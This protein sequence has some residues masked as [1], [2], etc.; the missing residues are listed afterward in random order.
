[1]ISNLKLLVKQ[2]SLYIH[3]IAKN[4]IH[5]FIEILLQLIQEFRKKKLIKKI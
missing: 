2:S 3:K 1:M 4:P 5:N